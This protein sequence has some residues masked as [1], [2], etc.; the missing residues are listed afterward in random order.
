MITTPTTLW[1][2][3]QALLATVETLR[4]RVAKLEQCIKDD[5]AL[6]IASTDK[7]RD[8]AAAVAAR[9]AA[10]AGVLETLIDD[11]EC[12][13]DHSGFCQTHTNQLDDG[14]CAMAVAIAVLAAMPTEALERAKL[15]K[16]LIRVSDAVIDSGRRLRSEPG[17][18]ELMLASLC[19]V[20]RGLA[21]LDTLGKE[22]E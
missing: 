4:A 22:E 16:E 6:Y 3:F 13:F 18:H 1:S 12:R 9:E 20:M 8:Q 14:R 5:S 7:L 17:A 19:C 10:L 2:D 21:K 11:D 15:G